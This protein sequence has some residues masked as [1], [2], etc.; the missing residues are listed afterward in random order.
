MKIDVPFFKSIRDTDCGP[1]VLKMVLGYFGEDYSFEEIS[2]AERQLDSGMVWTAGIARGARKFGFDVKIISTTNFSHDDDDID[3]Y[4]KYS[5]DDGMRIL[6]EL[7]AESRE[8]GVEFVEEDMNLEKLLS[9]ISVDSVPIVLVNWFSLA[10]REGYNGHFL[11]VVGY[12]DEYVYVHN[13]GL[14]SAMAYMPIKRSDFLRAWEFKG[15]DKDC[16]VVFRKK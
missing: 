8:I 2:E 12:D 1:M 6:G 4:D 11:V 5:G 7:L 10:G 16:V 3:Y 15:T 14:A 9:C 13:P